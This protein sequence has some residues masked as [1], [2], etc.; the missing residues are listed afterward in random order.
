MKYV[1]VAAALF[2]MSCGQSSKPAEKAPETAPEATPVAEQTVAGKLPDP[3]CEMPY[4][5]SYH[6]FTVYKTDTIHFCSPTC[7]EVFSK[8]PEKYMAKL[9]K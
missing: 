7:K 4:D 6:E 2:I 5:T 9:G 3:V 1:L 8:A